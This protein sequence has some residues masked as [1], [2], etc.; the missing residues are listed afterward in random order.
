MF[1]IAVIVTTQNR[2]AL[3]AEA[4]ASVAKQTMRV[5]EIIVVDDA[6]TSPISESSL[7]E[8]YGDVC[9]VIRNQTVRGLAYSRNLGVESSTSDIVMHLDDDD[10]LAQ[11]ALEHAFQV[12]TDAPKPDV[13]FLGA[14]GFGSQ[15]EHFNKVQPEAVS[16]VITMAGAHEDRDGVFIFDKRLFSALLQTVPIAFQRV[17]LHR[18]TWNQISA[19]RWHV[20]R[21]ENGINDDEAAKL[22]ITGP[23]RDSEWA[24]YAAASC[25][26]TVY[27]DRPLYLQRC[28]GQGYSSTPSNRQKHML[29][30]LAIK[31]ILMQGTRAIPQLSKWKLDAQANLAKTH[32][33]AAYQYQQQDNRRLAF[34]HLLK[35]IRLKPAWA[36]A[37]LMVKMLLPVRSR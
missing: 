7:R 33:D 5:R 30:G 28:D 6:S 21:L 25:Q 34:R 22:S 13:V 29:Q 31:T 20:Y 4:L 8:V 24:L 23:L 15:A 1:H 19:L 27:I 17:F 3:L 10:L 16:R 18:N 12:F 36:Q 11:D 26:C 32:F 37:R 9:K 14:K 35:A 2:P